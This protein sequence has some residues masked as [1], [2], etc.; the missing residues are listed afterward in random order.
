MAHIDIGIAPPPPE[1]RG[2]PSLYSDLVD[3]AL[4]HREEWVTMTVPKTPK[5]TAPHSG[6]LQ[7][8]GRYFCD[9][10]VQDDI[11]YLRIKEYGE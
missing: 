9:L 8:V 10:T 4:Q 1:R 6:I 3:T 5:S 2:R 11:I 7:L